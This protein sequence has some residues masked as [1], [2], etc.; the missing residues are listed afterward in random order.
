MTN[1]GFRASWRATGLNR[2]RMDAMSFAPQYRQ[3]LISAIQ[4]IDV[5]KEQQHIATRSGGE[6]Q[7]P[8]GKAEEAAAVIKACE[9]VREGQATEFRL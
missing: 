4:A 9:L 2:D 7:L 8:L 3:E 6:F 1:C 5:D